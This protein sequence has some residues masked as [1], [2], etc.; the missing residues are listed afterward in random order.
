MRS[1]FFLAALGFLAS[2]LSSD[3]FAQPG[4]H[5]GPGGGPPGGQTFQVAPDRLPVIDTHVHITPRKSIPGQ[6]NNS[7]IDMPGAIRNAMETMNQNGVRLSIIMS[8]PQEKEFERSDQFLR[9]L[10]FVA[11]KFPGRF[12]VLGGGSSLNPMINNAPKTGPV[13]AE[14]RRKFEEKAENILNQ[15]AIGFGEMTALHFSLFHGHPY[16]ETRPDHPLFLLLADIAGR[17]GVPIDLHME[18]A[19]STFDVPGE[20]QNRSSANPSLV[21]ENISAFERLLTHNRKARIVWVHAGWDNTGHRTPA[22]TLRLLRKHPNLYLNIKKSGRIN[23]FNSLLKGDGNIHPE[24]RKAILEFPHRFMFATDSFYTPPG[25]DGNMPAPEF[26]GVLKIFRHLPNRVARMIAFENAKRVYRLGGETG[27]QTP[28]GPPG[29]RIVSGIQPQRPKTDRRPFTEEEIRKRIIGNTIYFETPQGSRKV[30]IYFA[31][32]GKAIIEFENMPGRIIFK[33]WFFKKSGM[34]CR[35]YGK[36]NNNHCTKVRSGGAPE[37]FVFFNRNL[38][39][40]A[41]LYSGRRSASR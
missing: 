10:L 12:A 6:G 1:S 19:S 13:S 40:R 32:D 5:G 25:S 29:G 4:V 27:G 20:L 14:L 38:R 28:G 30:Y 3:I 35:T 8:G 26:P 18:A 33:K 15:G 36:K 41:T 39:Y 16:E 23:T 37:A 9:A 22:L 31:K 7:Q 11:K 34:L 17:H 24:W 21:D 2:T